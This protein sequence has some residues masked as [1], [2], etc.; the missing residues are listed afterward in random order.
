MSGTFSVK[1]TKMGM[2]PNG[3]TIMNKAIIALPNCKMKFKT[4]AKSKLTFSRA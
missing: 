3:S 2:F 4:N 1:P